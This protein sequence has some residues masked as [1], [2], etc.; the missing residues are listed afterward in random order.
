MAIGDATGGTSLAGQ[1]NFQGLGSGTDFST[2]ISKLVSVEQSRVATYTT[3][4]QS[5]L[6][7]NTA[8]KALNNTML[9]LRTTLQGMS[10]IGQFLQKTADSSNTT[11]LT[12]TAGGTAAAGTHTYS[13]KQL[14]QSKMMVTISGVA[15]L[16]Q[17][18]NA[19]GSAAKFIYDYKGIAVSNAIPASA[20]LADLVN[21]INTNGD[22]NGVRASTVFDGTKYYL[23]IRGLDTGAKSTLTIDPASTLAGFGA[24]NFA[25]VQNNQDAQIKI[26]GWPLSNAYIARSNNSISDVVTGLTFNLKSSGAG[27]VS[28]ST[29]TDAV[30]QNV[31]TFVS[32]V[33]QVRSQ[34][35]ALTKYD[36]TNKQGSILTGNYGLQMISTIMD[37][38]TADLGV[39][40]TVT[41][42]KYASLSPLGLNTDATEGSPTQGL[43]VLDEAAFTAALASDANAVGSIFSESFKGE[44]STADTS[45]Q[46]CI[47]GITKAGAYPVTYTVA[48]GK[49]TSATINGHAASFNSNSSF[50]TGASGQDESGLVLRVNNLTNGTY[51]ST[52]YLKEGKIPELVDS[53]TTLT[54]ATN[55][56]LNIL[57]NNYVTI[58]DDIQT[59]IDNENVRIAQMQTNLQAQFSK[60]DA[61]LGT[62]GQQTNALSSAVTQLSKQ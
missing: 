41:R 30:L 18:I 50:I 43:I 42:D 8:F 33:N 61:L 28:V 5:W 37:N 45:Y 46:S 60:L 10:T 1:I 22:N 29:N 39:G 21:I 53:L 25:T 32:Q 55:G 16:T 6:D 3:W 38:V 20:T 34:I 7:K 4:K 12:A 52:T 48:G 23:Q 19:L 62:Y 9:T 36:S 11:T 26:D 17:N 56:P 35:M 54:D 44:T 14:A 31:R 57:Q 51:S 27:S 47:Q 59:K 15:S 2:L 49:I 58:A 24:A 13:V 40:F